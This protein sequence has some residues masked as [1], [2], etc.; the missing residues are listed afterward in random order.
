MKLKEMEN[1]KNI[2]RKECFAKIHK[3]TSPWN[4]K[5]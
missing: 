3:V 1:D 2:N 5:D 4:Y